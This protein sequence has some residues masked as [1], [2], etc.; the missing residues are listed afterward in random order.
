M[1]TRTAYPAGVPGRPGVF[2]VQVETE[3]LIS[4][5]PL[6]PG[7][8]EIWSECAYDDEPGIYA[9]AAEAEKAALR[10]AT[11]LLADGCSQNWDGLAPE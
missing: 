1:I 2:F 8:T 9:S 11:G 5:D 7:G 4:A 10:I 3:W 6:D